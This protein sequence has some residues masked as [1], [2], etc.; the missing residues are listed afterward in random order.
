MKVKIGPYK[1]WV[2]PYQI[3]EK[4]CFWAKPVK[5]KHGFKHRPDWVHDFG[6]WLAGKDDHDTWLTKVC[7]WVEK[8]RTRNIQV[9]IHNYDTWSMDHTLAHIV[10]PMLKQL[11][12]T[13]H[14][15]PQ[16]AD[17]DVPDEL[18]SIW[19][20]PKEQE[21]D[22]DSNHFLRW[23]WVLNEMIF[24]FECKLDDDWENQYSSGKTDYVF[25]PCEGDSS[26]STMT[27]GPKHTYEID[28]E[29]LKKQQDRISNGFR[30]FGKYYESL[31]D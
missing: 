25:E 21:W 8:K 11:Q 27:E 28:S 12:D 22:I 30:L 9:K 7:L 17:E 20:L 19:A 31:W 5:D 1:N 6:E 13:K 16:V 10:L 2:G 4:L 14:G 23:D 24:A 15:A 18:R 29:G 3:A 26:L